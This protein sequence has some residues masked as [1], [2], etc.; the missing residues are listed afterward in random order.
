MKFEAARGGGGGVAWRLHQQ[1]ELESLH[2]LGIE[3]ATGHH[4]DL[5]LLRERYRFLRSI[6]KHHCNAD[7]ECFEDMKCIAAYVY[8]EEKLLSVL[9]NSATEI[10]ESHRRELSSST[11]AL[12]TSVSQ[13]LAKEQ[14]QV[15]PLLIEKFK[16]KEQAYI[17]W[18]FLC[19][20][21]VNMLAVFLP[22]LASS[23]SID[24][25]KELQKCLSKIVPGE[26]LLQQCCLESGKLIDCDETFIRQ[27]IGRFHLLRGFYKAHSNAED[28]ILF[29]ALE[30]K[31]T[32][33]R[34]NY[35]F[36]RN[37]GKGVA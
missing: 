18:R 36:R 19:S 24:E 4:V 3:F 10:D 32:L 1:R 22:W 20:I 25:S 35:I 5:C 17:V 29:P 16:H 14:K 27:F 37:K 12:K 31:E 13:N 33:D 26:K 23:I 15:F 9:L 7:D 8:Y 28:D 2:R 30:S 34:F 6:Y 21:P 11:G